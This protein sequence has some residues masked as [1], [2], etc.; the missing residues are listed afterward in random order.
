MLKITQKIAI[1]KNFLISM[2]FVC[3]IFTTWG[4]TIDDS[5]AVDLNETSAEMEI[6]LDVEDE[7]ENSQNEILGVANN[8]KD[9]ILAAKS[10]TLNGGSFSDIQKVVDQ[11]K[12]GDKIILKG[13][14]V[15]K[16]SNDGIV[17]NKK[18]GE[19]IKKGD[20]IAYVHT[21]RKEIVNNMSYVSKYIYSLEKN[22]NEKYIIF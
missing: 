10:Y 7:L 5:Y 2:L 13:T 11:S 20:I 15:S 3:L 12:A 8:N 6:G 17:I 22:R 19:Q 14:F 4:L 16:D 1:S 9:E 18:L 21:N